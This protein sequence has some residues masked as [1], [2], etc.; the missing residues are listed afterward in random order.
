M[1]FVLSGMNTRVHLSNR[2]GSII[3]FCVSDFTVTLNEHKRASLRLHIRRRRSTT[4]T[5][6]SSQW[7]V[8]ESC[9]LSAK[10]N[11]DN[12]VVFLNRF[13]FHASAQLKNPDVWWKCYFGGSHICRL[14]W[15]TYFADTG[16]TC[17]AI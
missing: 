13:K 16:A 14:S 15:W 8:E 1:C 9:V 6:H 3:L 17:R 2:C 10:R 5:T 4:V 7:M 12:G 11:G